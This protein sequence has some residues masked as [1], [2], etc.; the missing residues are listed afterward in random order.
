MWVD[1]RPKLIDTLKGYNREK[2]AA[3]LTAGI[4]VGIVALP[5][6][7]ALAIASG[8]NPER[9]LITAVIGG[10]L[11]SMLGGSRVQIAGPTGAFIVILYGIVA[12][13]GV[14]GLLLA[15]MMAGVMTVLFGVLKIGTLI[16]FMPYPIIVGFTSGIA[17]IILFSQVKDFF[18]MGG[19]DV[20]A[21]TIDKLVFYAQHATTLNPYALLLG[22]ATILITVYGGRISSKIPGSL[23]AIIG[24]VVV[25]NVFNLPVET[26]GSKFG[27]L[28]AQ[29]P[30][31]ELP[32]MSFSSFRVLLLPAFSIAM[33]GSIESLLSA[34]VADGA[35]GYRHRPNTELIA[36]GVA[37]IVVP[38]FGGIP[39]CGAIARTM[40]NIRNGG[41]TPVAG[42]MHAVVV[43]MILLFFGKWARLI[44]M[45][46]LA[47]ILFVVAYN[48]SEWRS[49]KGMFRN[50]KSDL[51]VMLVT[52]LLTV[53]VDITVAIQFGV[54]LAAFLFVRRVVET[55]EVALLTT[56]VKGETSH[57]SDDQ[58]HLEI[59]EGVEVF[60][61][62]GPFFFGVVNKFYEADKQLGQKPRVRIIRMRL[63]PFI[64]STGIKNLESFIHKTRKSNIPIIFSGLQEKT[65]HALERAGV[66]AM[67]GNENIC[68]E[69]H[70][71]LQRARQIMEKDIG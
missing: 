49:F 71:A 56:E 66:L 68:P 17:L 38:L 37:N 14:E 29:I 67:V 28:S 48:M 39:A 26:I 34:M 54:V 12:E 50:T 7:I 2:L 55:S 20:P 3:D 46:A 24:S 21:D 25:V 13:F 59:P 31:P 52:F 57:I 22:M 18:G 43:L 6:S 58:E 5:L 45:P 36:N 15:T 8:V 41:L 4:V 62:R 69:I 10:F 27:E 51:S 35:T 61:V 63:V 30:S 9:G 19:G 70:T 44:P 65:H 42:M 64:D 32:Q 60:Q 47:G 53:L 1:F 33:L 11:I 23:L 40:T 16:Q